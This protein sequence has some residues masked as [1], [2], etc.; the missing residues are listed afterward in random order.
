MSRFNTC[1]GCD[2]SDV[3]V[4]E[5]MQTR[6]SDPSSL[7]CVLVLC[8]PCGGEPSVGADAPLPADRIPSCGTT[9]QIS[10]WVEN[11]GAQ[12]GIAFHE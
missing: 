10:T 8:G 11:H 12:H 3:P 1:D 7:C 9:E 2:R 6:P 5:C 4:F